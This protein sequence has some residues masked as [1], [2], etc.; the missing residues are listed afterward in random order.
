[1]SSLDVPETL[2]LLWRGACKVRPVEVLLPRPRGLLQVLA[3]G[4]PAALGVAPDA[5][6]VAGAAV[7]VLGTAAHRLVRQRKALALAVVG[8]QL[9]LGAL[10]LVI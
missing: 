8:G 3:G 2:A 5:S 9:G 7:A 10:K 1:M 6:L 4:A